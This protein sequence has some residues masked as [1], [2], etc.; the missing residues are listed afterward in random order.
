MSTALPAFCMPGWPHLESTSRKPDTRT[1][2]SWSGRC[3]T[4]S[5]SQNRGPLRGKG[6]GTIIIHEHTPVGTGFHRTV[7]VT[8]LSRAKGRG[9]AVWGRLGCGGYGGGAR[10][11]Q[12]VG[13]NLACLVWVTLRGRCWQPCSGH[14][15][16][17]SG[18]HRQNDY[19]YLH[20]NPHHWEAPTTI[21][22]RML[23]WKV[24]I[25]TLLT[26]DTRYP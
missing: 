8:A 2:A 14:W 6:A 21:L 15:A 4:A 11:A 12:Q 22:G 23:S 7:L 20:G 25:C 24:H 16:R 3:S 1:R 17:K 19:F 13:D 5:R 26:A 18:P 9:G 10:L